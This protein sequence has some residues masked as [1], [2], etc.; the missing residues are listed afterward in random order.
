MMARTLRDFIATGLVPFDNIYMGQMRE[1]EAVVL[2][3]CGLSA[4]QGTGCAWTPCYA[5]ASIM[6]GLIVQMESGW[7]VSSADASSMLCL[8][9]FLCSIVSVFL[10]S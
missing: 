6:R 4:A 2:S 7:I 1:S 3:E 9:S 8:D 10:F 5:N